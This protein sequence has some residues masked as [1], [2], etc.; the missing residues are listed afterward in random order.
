MQNFPVA[1]NA[2]EAVFWAALGCEFVRRGTK[3]RGGVRGR[4]FV[5]G[6]AFVLFAGS[7]VVEIATG[8]W[9]R[10]WG[11]LVWKAGCVV[12]LACLYAE[13]VLWRRRS[14]QQASGTF[15]AGASGNFADAPDEKR[16]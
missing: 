8:A 3:L 11:L 2:F 15:S 10:P 7:D 13:S 4:C 14:S 5:A 6:L 9:W 1:F 12:V 16:W